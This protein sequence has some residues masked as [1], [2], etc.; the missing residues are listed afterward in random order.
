MGLRILAGA[1]LPVL[2]AW[3]LSAAALP[4]F[5]GAIGYGTDTAAG[6]HG[7]IYR[8]NSLSD[9]PTDAASPSIT[10]LR[11]A[12]QA[13]GPRT[14]IFEISGTIT[15]TDP[16]IISSPF[17]TVAG[18]TAPYP[19]IMVRGYS[20]DVITHDV[21]IQHL[22][23]RPGDDNALP[24]GDPQV[25]RN[26]RDAFRVF[27]PRN[28]TSAEVYNVVLDHVSGSW[29]TDQSMQVY[30]DHP[31]FFVHDVTVS[32]SL[33]AEPLHHSI[34]SPK[35]AGGGYV[36]HGFGPLIGGR[37]QRTTFLRNVTAYNEARNP[38]I[39]DNSTDLVN[40]N[41]LTV[42]PSTYSSARF[43]IGEAFTGAAQVNASVVGNLS[44]Y[45]PANQNTQYAYIDSKAASNI[46]LYLE[47][48]AA[49]D[50]HLNGNNGAWLPANNNQWD[51]GFTFTGGRRIDA[52][53]PTGD[54]NLPPV[55][56]LTPP[57]WHTG[58]TAWTTDIESRVR[59]AAGARPADRDPVDAR[60][61]LNM[62]NW[63]GPTPTTAYIN[64]PADIGGYPTLAVN[65]R[66][67]TAPDTNA[68]SDGDG[69]SDLEEWLHA[70]AAVVEGR[71]DP[72]AVIQK[73]FESGNDAADW[74]LVGTGAWARTTDG[75]STVFRQS[76]TAPDTRMI[77]TGSNW[78]NQSIQTDVKI[79][80]FSGIDHWVGLSAR[81]TDMNNHYFLTLR[82]TN[83]LDLRKKVNG[84]VTTLATTPLTVATNTWYR[85]R[86][87]VVGNALNVYLNG[88]AEPVLTATDA[89]LPQGSMALSMWGADASFDNV[90]AT[91][92]AQSTLLS[93]NFNDGNAAGWTAG[94]GTWSVVNDGSGAI[95]YQQSNLVG[96]AYATA[97]SGW[98]NQIIE[99]DLRATAFDSAPTEDWLG[100]GGR[101]TD[102]NN[103]YY[104]T[105]RNSNTLILR[106]VVGGTFTSLDS[107]AFTVSPGVTYHV[108][109]EMIGTS[110]K[111]YIDGT[112]LLEATDSALP[113]GG[114]ILRT[115]RASVLYDNVQV[116]RP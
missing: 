88:A 39:K 59:N 89:S 32:H 44:I 91:P 62:Q 68:D 76:N 18:Q 87:E 50:P 27:M 15:I 41:N 97:G 8:V 21:L 98:T 6:R 36:D 85:L 65:V 63:V 2:A 110:I 29:T 12:L 38:L 109:L 69:Y 7:T 49:W 79:Q 42:W 31:T 95:V 1:S 78:T 54:P 30:G 99:A 57:V 116:L 113:T 111:V 5:P 81:Y 96:D 71:L 64:S 83:T 4:V 11:E 112:L 37:T 56:A 67:L 9:S 94:A 115:F 106:K 70:Y 35:T 34:H 92:N 48:N 61:V 103:H 82:Q 108:R 45:R 10:T 24:P 75:A 55:K 25:K 66:A 47:G 43:V 19:G 73:D 28:A 86:L 74:T 90:V 3:S 100:I 80:S 104:V 58:L 16:I 84:T 93:D 17:I 101:Y 26:D 107:T 23:V 60:I 51:T 105:L 22:A 52:A 14:V 102:F 46:Q 114:V 20:I 77:L 33:F 13:T 40:V 72:A 53:D